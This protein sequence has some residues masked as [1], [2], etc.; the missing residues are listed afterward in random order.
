M[1]G[2]RVVA[3]I[4]SPIRGGDGNL[5]ASALHARRKEKRPGVDT[6]A[7]ECVRYGCI[8]EHYLRAPYAVVAGGVQIEDVVAILRPSGRA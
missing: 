5:D 2:F 8:T 4:N 1:E 6:G 7:S 3:A